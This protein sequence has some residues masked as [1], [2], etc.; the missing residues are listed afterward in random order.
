MAL[1]TYNP[2]VEN[3]LDNLFKKVLNDFSEGV[4][5]SKPDSFSPRTDIYETEQ[6]FVMELSV[7]GMKKEDFKIDIDNDVL[8]ISG[9]RKLE[10]LEGVKYHRRE[11]LS[12]SFK[13]SYKIT[14][15][16]DVENITA[17]YENGILS[18]SLPKVEKK[19]NKKVIEIK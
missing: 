14:D 15:L 7:P 12:G 6:K 3:S 5:D 4:I 2:R 9:E 13:K 11:T 1:L 19:E 16:I 17:G 8:I 10:E 18:V